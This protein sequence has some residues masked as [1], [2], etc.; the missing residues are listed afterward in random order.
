[1]TQK[2]SKTN[3]KPQHVKA[4][5]GVDAGAQ[6]N[7]PRKGGAGGEY[8]L[9]LPGPLLAVEDNFG[10]LR[11]FHFLEEMQKRER[12][13]GPPDTKLGGRT[14]FLMGRDQPCTYMGPGAEREPREAAGSALLLGHLTGVLGHSDVINVW[15]R[16]LWGPGVLSRTTHGREN[17]S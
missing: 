5:N 2:Q 13:P 11:I 10:V 8:S 3:R 12:R 9:A 6:G 1:M 16:P 15:P 4:A 14:G 17:A 7:R